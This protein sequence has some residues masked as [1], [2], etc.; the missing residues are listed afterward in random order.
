MDAKGKVNVLVTGGA[1]YIGSM[2]CKV[3]TNAGYNITVFDNLSTG[4]KELALFGDFIEGDLL[5]KADLEEIF[6]TK[7]FDVVVHFAALALVGNSVKDP[8]S[9][10]ENNVT[11][12][13][14]LLE[15][16]AKY[17]T[18]ALVFS[19]TAAVYG[20]P[21]RIPIIEE[22]SLNPINPYGKTKL[23]IEWLLQ[24]SVSAYGINHLAFRYFN[25]CGADPE[26][27]CGEWH[28][29][30]THLIP[31]ILRAALGL[32]NEL[33]IFGTNFP[34]ADGTC[35]RDYIHVYDLA[36]AHRLAIAYLLD[37]GF[38]RSLNLGS[39]KGTSV[40]QMH[41]L[42][43]RITGRDIPFLIEEPRAGDPAIL[44]ASSE[45]AKRALGWKPVY[46]DPEIMLKH[47][48][49]WHQK[50]GFSPALKGK[51]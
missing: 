20:E 21:C 37:G 2:T 6:S 1:G 45:K 11:G 17:G 33:K 38:S 24:D 47:A 43:C 44:I 22:H 32:A 49:A 34:T 19:S 40:K 51:T 27:Q 41:Q 48:W 10:Y 35:V 36:E 3:L 16:M 13:L 39:S 30:E 18:K 23:C 50:N 5:C 9:Y 15:T 31:N 25:A 46:D 4:H 12:T 28:E 42:A 26:G 14:N 7:S 8:F 29:P